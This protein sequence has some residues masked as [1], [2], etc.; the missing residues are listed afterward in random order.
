MID[1]KEREI[2]GETMTVARRTQI[3]QSI[4]TERSQDSQL[5][6]HSNAVIGVYLEKNKRE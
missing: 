3:L 2:I 6:A 1:R 5:T 4:S